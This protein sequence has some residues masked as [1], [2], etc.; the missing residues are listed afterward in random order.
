MSEVTNSNI[1]NQ[2]ELYNSKSK[3]VRAFLCGQLNVS[4]DQKWMGENVASGWIKQVI[5]QGDYEKKWEIGY[6]SSCNFYYKGYIDSLYNVGS[7]ASKSFYTELA[8]YE[9]DMSSINRDCALTKYSSDGLTV[10]KRFDFRIENI[11]LYFFPHNVVLCSI[12]ISESDISLND[13]T[14]LHLKLREVLEYDNLRKM[15]DGKREYDYFA[16]DNYLEAIDPLIKLCKRANRDRSF[17]MID[18]VKNGNKFKLFQIVEAGEYYAKAN[19]ISQQQTPYFTTE[20]QTNEL[21][22]EV[23]TL[24]KIGV[25]DEIDNRNSPSKSYY[26]ALVSGNI[27]EPYRNWKALSIFDTFSVIYSHSLE[28]NE[29]ARYFRLIY[30]HAIYQKIVLFELNQDFRAAAIAQKGLTEL[31]EKMKDH[32]C[33]Y[34]FPNISY[35]FQPQMIYEQILK[36]LNVE[37]ERTQLRYYLEQESTRREKMR[38]SR[39]K[40]YANAFTLLL[41]FVTF[42]SLSSALNDST[43][44]Y[45]A[46]TGAE[47]T[48]CCLRQFICY[49]AQ[50]ISLI[51]ILILA[52]MAFVYIRNKIKEW[53]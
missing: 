39:N 9:H 38:E 10:I 43:S 47:N 25:I 45:I 40:W 29:W 46:W 32:E 14:Y 28:T 8:E 23:A 5:D 52:P 19:E 4:I 26:E 7:S 30:L 27:I 12:E 36:G 31:V 33:Y 13:M 37:A 16:F 17:E 50:L 49:G 24:N 41:G 44:L 22:Y 11:K 18:L 20:Q 42:L 3:V 53:R 51:T 6:N 35:N 1:D 48:S 2:S 21:L 15:G 34:G